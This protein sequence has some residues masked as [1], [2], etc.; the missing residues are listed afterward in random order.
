MKVFYSQR[1]K[2]KRKHF[3]DFFLL[4]TIMMMVIPFFLPMFLF[5]GMR[6]F[7]SV[8]ALAGLAA[9]ALSPFYLVKLWM[10][11][12]KFCRDVVFALDSYGRLFLLPWGKRTGMGHK[13]RMAV[14]DVEAALDAHGT[15]Q[16]LPP[17]SRE[18]LHVYRVQEKKD[19]WKVRAE[20]QGKYI[21][22]RTTAIFDRSY[23]DLPE[24]L[25]ILER[26]SLQ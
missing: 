16:Q 5:Q 6:L 4:R 11:Y 18:V 1:K 22:Y 14:I 15:V 24:L 12:R 23:N 13:G 3:S 8:W 17:F 20:I 10:D 7:H 21:T 26:K 2:D 9:L 19:G 25:H